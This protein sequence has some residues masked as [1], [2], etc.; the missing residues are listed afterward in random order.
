MLGH[1]SLG[2]NTS[3]LRHMTYHTIH[4][5]TPSKC[6]AVYRARR[7]GFNAAEAI[8]PYVTTLPLL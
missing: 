8:G 5:E 2:R 6:S 4:S 1:A 7:A 3:I